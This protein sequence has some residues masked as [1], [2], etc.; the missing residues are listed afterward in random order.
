MVTRGVSGLILGSPRRV[1]PVG[2]RVQL[3]LGERSD[4]ENRDD[5]DPGRVSWPFR[6]V[7]ISLARLP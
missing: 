3:R 7:F 4:V 2:T 1:N 5:S 6:T